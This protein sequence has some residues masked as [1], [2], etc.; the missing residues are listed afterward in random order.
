MAKFVLIYTGSGEP[1]GEEAQKAVMDAW[2]AWFGKMGDAVVD[3][4]EAFGQSKLVTAS[5]ISDG[6]AGTPPPS[7]YTIISANSLTEAAEAIADHPHVG[8]GG[9]ISVFELMEM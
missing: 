5:G 8:F 7:G 2:M 6:A 3:A 9:E 1:E 4:G